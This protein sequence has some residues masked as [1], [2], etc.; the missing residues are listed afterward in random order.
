MTY[1]CQGREAIVNYRGQGF[2]QHDPII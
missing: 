2:Q 1:Q